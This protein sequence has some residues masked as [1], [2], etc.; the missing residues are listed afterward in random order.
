MNSLRKTSTRHDSRLPFPR[1]N[2][3]GIRV[4]TQT[5]SAPSSVFSPTA[6]LLPG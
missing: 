1:P 2:K 5:G 6:T 4:S 3:P